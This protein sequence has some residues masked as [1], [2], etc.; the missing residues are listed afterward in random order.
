M[1]AEAAAAAGAGSAA[2]TMSNAAGSLLL[3]M[4]VLGA[5]ANIIAGIRAKKEAKD[6][7]RAAK[8][9]TAEAIKSIEV[10]RMEG[11]Q[12]P[13]DAF[14]LQSRDV[15]AGQQ[16]AVQA[17]QEGGQRAIIGG[18]GRVQASGT[19]GLERIRQAMQQALTTRDMAIAENQTKIDQSLAGINLGRA[20]GAQERSREQE[21]IGNLR[22]QSGVKD[23]G[24]AVA[25]FIG[26]QNLF[27][28]QG[29]GDQPDRQDVT[30]AV[31]Q[32]TPEYSI[33]ALSSDSMTD[34]D[35]YLQM[36]QATGGS[37]GLDKIDN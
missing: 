3:A 9:A 15:V 36:L 7:A 31:T 22:I 23:L 32:S 14:E 6:A 8:A 20:A 27:K 30:S 35:R 2:G 10:N 11:V 24:S 17:L 21:M 4:N 1:A 13:L 26:S 37:L 19:Q 18:L 12:V 28:N 16:Q 25:K 5:G 33:P 29:I 34:I